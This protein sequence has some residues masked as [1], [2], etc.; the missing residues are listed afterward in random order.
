MAEPDGCEDVVAASA[1][2][3]AWFD[4]LGDAAAG[5]PADPSFEFRFGPFDGLA[6]E[7]AQGFPE[8]PRAVEL[9]LGIRVGECGE[10]RGSAFGQVAGVPGHGVFDAAHRP[11][12]R[13]VP[14]AP[15]L[16]PQPFPDPVERVGHPG[17][18]VERVEHAFGV[19][20]VPGHGRVDPSGPVAGHDPDRRAPLRRQLP[21]E[22]VEDLSAVPVVRPDHASAP[23]AD[24]DGD[25]RVALPAAGLVHTDRV[26]PVE[27]ARHRG[28]QPAGDP[29]GDVAGGPPRDMQETAHG[30][31][32]GDR[33]QPCA[34]GSEVAGEPAARP[35]PRHPGDHHAVRTAF[36]CVASSSGVP[37]ERGK[38]YQVIGW[39][40]AV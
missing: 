28:P 23:V 14:V 31:L 17:D 21:E 29:S 10:G 12:R 13:C 18:D 20:A 22:Q 19:R 5:R 34:P 37:F 24:D 39:F 40:V 26:Q 4:D 36:H 27:H 3:P 30:L 35:G 2:L 38:V 11:G 7:R 1:D 15:G 33:H 9:A 6:R 25:A 16:V 8:L 32:A